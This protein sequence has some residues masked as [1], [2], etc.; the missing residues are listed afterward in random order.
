MK[1]IVD[2]SMTSADAESIIVGI[3]N[4]DNIDLSKKPLAIAI[5]YKENIL[6]KYDYIQAHNT[7]E[8][9]ISNTV[10]KSIKNT[11]E[12]DTYKQ[13]NEYMDKMENCRK[14][15]MAILKNIQKISIDELRSACE[16]LFEK[17]PND[18]AVETNA[19][20]CIMCLDY[21][22]NFGK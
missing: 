12:F 11:P 20:R 10:A 22:Q 14:T 8:K 21:R 3:D 7:M 4:L 6:N 5:G 16:Y 17:Y 13:L 19:K 1:T 9:I 18:Y 15:A 2:Q